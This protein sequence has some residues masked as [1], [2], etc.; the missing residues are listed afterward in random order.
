VVGVKLGPLLSSPPQAAAS[1]SRK[2][3]RTR[4]FIFRVY[5]TVEAERPLRPLALAAARGYA[6][7]KP[8]LDQPIDQQQHPADQQSR[9]SV[10]LKQ[11]K[12]HASPSPA[13]GNSAG[14][15]GRCHELPTTNH[16]PRTTNHEPPTTNHQ[17]VLIP[18]VTP[19]VT[20]WPGA[21]EC[22]GALTRGARRSRRFHRTRPRRCSR[23]PTAHASRARVRARTR[24]P[25]RRDQQTP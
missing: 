23:P 8:A 13:A 24:R 14:E 21:R 4:R 22:R 5:T 7:R 3:G 17:P 19:Q 2:I 18:R 25:A 9:Q 6:E 16:E 10:R 11:I 15:V 1:M 12:I 20:A